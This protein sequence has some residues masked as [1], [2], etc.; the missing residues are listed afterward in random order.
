M[1]NVVRVGGLLTVLV[2][3]VFFLVMFRRDR[4]TARLQR[5]PGE[6]SGHIR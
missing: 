2:L 4:R 3:G 1:M 5:A 6:G